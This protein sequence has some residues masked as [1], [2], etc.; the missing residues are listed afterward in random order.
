[1]GEVNHYNDD[2]EDEFFDA[3]DY[4]AFDIQNASP[5][6][7]RSVTTTLLEGHHSASKH[8]C[9]PK[10]TFNPEIDIPS[11]AYKELSSEGVKL[12]YQFD[13]KDPKIIVSMHE[14]PKEGS[15]AMVPYNKP[16][17][18]TS[19]RSKHGNPPINPLR[20]LTNIVDPG[21]EVVTRNDLKVFASQ[22]ISSLTSPTTEQPEYQILSA[23][24]KK[25]DLPLLSSLPQGAPVQ[26]LADTLPTTPGTYHIS[27]KADGK[28]AS[29]R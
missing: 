19:Q 4:T 10:R 1:M 26:R 7:L 15:S 21:D 27:E 23:T 24:S 13:N 29:K 20:N 12:W 16:N 17:P 2:F 5:D 14:Y 25:E 9:C 22:I 18:T 11:A 8:N 28:G 3:T 6:T